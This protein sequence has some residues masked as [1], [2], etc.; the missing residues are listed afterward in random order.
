MK[1]T[2]FA[3][4]IF[5]LL[6][7][8]PF[9]LK[10]AKEIADSADSADTL[11]IVTPHVDTIKSE[12][13]HAFKE[14]YFKK[15]NR[16][17]K[18][19]YRNIG[20]TSD[21]LRYIS[22][23]FESE[24]RRYYEKK[25]GK[26]N[27]VVQGAFTRDQK[28]DAPLEARN[29]RKMF[30]ESDIGIGIDLF[31]GGGTFDQA[32]MAQMGYAADG[33]VKKRHPEYFSENAIP[34]AFAGETFYDKNG[35]YYGVCL[36]SFGICINPDA[37]AE[38]GINPSDIKCWDDMARVEF[39]GKVVVADPSKSGSVTKCFESILQEKM[40]KAV[41]KY[42]V[43]KGLEIGFAE[44]FELIRRIVANS[45]SV[46]DGAGKV[47]REV[48]AGDGAIGMAIDFYT[49]A[50]QQ[51]TTAMSLEGR[52]KIRYITPEGG[53]FV[54]ADPIQLLRGAENKK[55]ACEFIDFCLSKEGQKLWNHRVG[56]KNGPRK[57]ALLRPPIRRDVHL[58]ADKNDL[59][60][61]SYNPYE[62]SKN[63]YYN[64][65]WTGPYFNLIR[66]LIRTTMLDAIEEMRAAHKAILDAGGYDKVPRAAAVF[67]KMIVPYSEAKK[68][69]AQLRVSAGHS[70]VDVAAVRRKWSSEAIKNYRE[71][72]EL[73]RKGL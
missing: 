41:K 53:S 73:A 46:T 3:F 5:I 14:Y 24:F 28:P 13:E 15:Y 1:K 39:F 37:V 50:E 47:T 71:A 44:G 58:E 48:G 65:R 25:G 70:A 10:P 42:G 66:I 29:A 59:S 21:I 36:S 27:P 57:Y 4:G 63:V 12:F 69:S 18:F 8:I 40:Y 54:S 56:V 2:V 16:S 22:D 6:L 19:D 68:A 23:R 9:I 17:V 35:L 20:G 52:E 62:S 7:V 43:E 26:W 30:L 49:L 33:E 32:K 11:V 34:A 55:V 72:F 38:C 51:F 45:R 31:F 64:G 60:P 61:G 67:N